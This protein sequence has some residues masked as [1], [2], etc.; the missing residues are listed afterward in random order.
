M[1]SVRDF[2]NLG[3]DEVIIREYNAVKI[4][5]PTKMDGNIC[6]TNKR[7]ILYGKTEAFLGLG[8]SQIASDIHM[9]VIKGTEIFA[10]AGIHFWWVLA[11]II[12]V[13]FGIT[14]LQESINLLIFLA[15]LAAIA[16]AILRKEKG[17]KIIIKG[18]NIDPPLSIGRERYSVAQRG[19]DAEAL[20]REL[21][22]MILDIQMRGD[23]VLKDIK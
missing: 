23:E 14:N 5:A 17:F 12:A 10:E 18:Q 21:G 4:L 7:A 15:G 1:P 19:P 11:G 8:T 20:I 16:F 6:L 9:D 22:A 3:R 2:I 13:I